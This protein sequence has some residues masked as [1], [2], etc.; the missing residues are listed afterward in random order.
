[1]YLNVE[2]M[3]GNAGTVRR[4]RLTFDVFESVLSFVVV[5]YAAR[6]RLTFDVFEFPEQL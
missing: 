3:A 6:L 4:L 5:F 2:S 1:M